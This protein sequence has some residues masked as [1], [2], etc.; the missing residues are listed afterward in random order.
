[1]KEKISFIVPTL[2]EEKNIKDTIDTIERNIP[3]ERLDWEIIV[4]DGGSSD[5]TVEIIN[6]L[7][8]KNDKIRLIGD[9]EIKGLGHAYKKGVVAANGDYI[10]M[11]PGDNEISGEAISL[12]LDNAGQKDMIVP[13]F[14]NQEI[15]P[16]SRQIISRNFTRL[17]NAISGLDL[18]YYNGTV[19]YRKEVIR[20]YNFITYGFAYQAEILINRIRAGFTYKEIAT[21]IQERSSGKTKIFSIR[22]IGSVFASLVR[23]F[24][25]Y[26]IAPLFGGFGFAK[27]KPSVKYSFVSISGGE[28]KR[29]AVPGEMNY[30]AAFLT[31]ACPM[32]CSYCI[33]NYENKIL[34][35][36]LMDG[37]RWV[38]GLNRLG[39]RH[40][41]PVTLQGGEPTLHKDFYYIIEN[42]R[43]DIE[44][45]ILTNLQFDL[46]KFIDRVDPKRINRDDKLQ[47]IRASYHPEGMDID[48]TIEKILRLWGAG[49]NV[50]LG[51]VLH[52]KQEEQML[53][54]SRKAKEAGIFFFT[55]EFLGFHDGRLYGTYRYPDAV[56]C[57]MKKN[58]QCRTTEVL[59]GPLGE[60]Y[61]CTRDVYTDNEPIAH[62]L[63][64]DLKIDYKHCFCRNF[65]YCNPCDI[66]VKTNRFLEYGHTSVDIKFIENKSK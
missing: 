37:E 53:V 33:N 27:I 13:Y 54:A 28:E 62:L 12:I 34:Q 58:V 43:P 7:S 52:P 14:T 66:K 38:W 8:E 6:A 64:P 59:I 18:K 51:G 1:M 61:K 50:G 45:D 35:K 56:K 10:M 16:I 26:R 19:L 23:L 41:L 49:F 44:I 22:N 40:N 31:F 29:V 24:W 21:K 65:G 42:L 11:V 25:L 57:E 55:K 4:V 2:N 39:L 32:S 60:I 9:E 15:R 47:S 20:G 48:E 3:R 36:D 46:D 17:L 63:D 30:I 5:R